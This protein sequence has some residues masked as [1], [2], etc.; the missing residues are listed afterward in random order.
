VFFRPIRKIAKGDF[1]FR[2]FCLSLRLS[3]R[4][5]V[6][7]NSAPNGLIFMIPEF[8]RF[9]ESLSRK[10]KFHYNV[11]SITGTLHEHFCT[12]MTI[13]QFFLEWEMFQTKVVEEI[14]TDIVFSIFFFFSENR[15]VY[16]IMWKKMVEPDRPQVTIPRRK[17]TICMPDN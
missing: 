14:K 6:W 11:T 16:E 4:L 9:F 1:W 17:Y 2:Q 7:N 13:S 12:F 10:S 5:S 15:A 3:V 8:W